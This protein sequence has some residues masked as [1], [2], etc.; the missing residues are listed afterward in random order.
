MKPSDSPSTPPHTPSSPRLRLQKTPNLQ[1]TKRALSP[2]AAKPVVALKEEKQQAQPKPAEAKKSKAVLVVSL[3]GVGVAAGGAACWYGFAPPS[4]NAAVAAVAAAEAESAPAAEVPAEDTTA[5]AVEPAAEDAAPTTEEEAAAPE[6]PA[7]PPVPQMAAEFLG[8]ALEPEESYDL[9]PASAV[10]ADNTQ[11]EEEKEERSKK[12]SPGKGELF[13]AELIDIPVVRRK[14]FTEEPQYTRL[15]TANG[16]YVVTYHEKGFAVLDFWDSHSMRY[17]MSARVADASDLD[18]SSRDLWYLYQPQ[19]QLLSFCIYQ[20]YNACT[21]DGVYLYGYDLKHRAQAPAAM[22]RSYDAMNYEVIHHVPYCRDWYM[23]S[24]YS[25]LHGSLNADEKLVFNPTPSYPGGKPLPALSQ[26]FYVADYCFSFR[27]RTVPRIEEIDAAELAWTSRSQDTAQQSTVSDSILMGEAAKL[28]KMKASDL[29]VEELAD[30]PLSFVFPKKYGTVW[31]AGRAKGFEKDPQ[32][33]FC[34]LDRQRGAVYPAIEDV[35]FW[36]WGPIPVCAMTGSSNAAVTPISIR[37]DSTGTMGTAWDGSY[38]YD[39]DHGTCY[40]TWMSEEYMVPESGFRKIEVLRSKIPGKHIATG[41]G[42]SLNAWHSGAEH[43]FWIEAGDGY[44]KLYSVDLENKHIEEVKSWNGQWSEGSETRPVWLADKQWLF[45]P[46]AENSWKI[47]HI[48]EGEGGI[49]CSLLSYLFLHSGHQYAFVLPNGHYAGTPGCESFL[50]AR[51]DDAYTDLGVLA[52][53]RNRPAEVAAALGG[54]QE[55]CEMLAAATSRWLTKLGYKPRADG[56]IGAEPNISS[57]PVAQVEAPAVKAEGSTCSFTLRLKAMATPARAE[58]RV[59]GALVE[60]TDEVPAGDC[61]EITQKVELALGTNWVEVTPYTYRDKVRVIGDTK[62]FRTICSVGEESELY[63]VTLGV[64]EYE[65]SSL[66]LQYAAKDAR[67]MAECFRTKGMGKVHALCLTDGEVRHD[68]ALQKISDFLST[69]HPGDRIVCYVAGHGLLDEKLDYYYA[70]VDIDP[71]N[72][73]AT[74]IS[75]D[76]LTDCLQQQPARQRL[77]LLD[78][79]HSGVLGE[80]GE[81]KMA[82]AMGNLPPGVRAVQHRGMKVKKVE[83]ALNTQQKKRYIETLFSMGKSQRGLNIIAGA[84]GAE[85]ALESTE[86]NNGVFTASVMEAMQQ[87]EKADKNQDGAVSVS[88]LERYTAEAVSART[89]GAQKPALSAMESPETFQLG[90]ES[91]F[92]TTSVSAAL[93]ACKSL[94]ERGIVDLEARDAKGNTPLL[95]AT[96]D[97]NS[98]LVKLLV[99]AGADVNARN[100]AGDA[101]LMN[102]ACCGDT[103]MVKLLYEHHADVNAQDKDGRNALMLAINGGHEQLAKTLA[104]DYFADTTVTDKKGEKASGLAKKKGMSELARKLGEWTGEN[105]SDAYAGWSAAQL[106]QEGG[107]LSDAGQQEQAMQL[108]RRAADAGDS[109]AQRWLGFRYLN[110]RGVAKDKNQAKFWFGKAA[111]QGDSG[112]AQA[113]KDIR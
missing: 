25:D 76:A 13:D 107:R 7:A 42:T 98:E 11:T 66:K 71:E 36:C 103:S 78:T 88:E 97:G 40:V 34:L 91:E 113:L 18:S 64:S 39:A 62:R 53:W 38:L 4:E 6:P 86:W 63:V 5:V 56:D 59:N 67:D 105:T 84:A 80:E 100:A 92:D 28:L 12:I 55:T 2:L 3:L 52:P 74:G 9:P 72:V 75:M 102:A 51:E 54:S 90:A 82:L 21:V 16:D 46:V 32:A 57:L 45:I 43:S 30:S 47:Y 96:A 26:N 24:P 77:L 85:F 17:L 23:S 112:A 93:S 58:I 27:E 65:D 109:T 31:E 20:N 29:T 99:E 33:D 89:N 61:A 104:F 10:L 49:R 111:A 94:R 101:P 1:Q 37:W 35:D 22:I 106:R 79:C 70:P 108:I 50:Y 44:C 83:T 8:A 95:K 87:P 19:S 48:E 14:E 81:E 60:E 69:A 110:G 41:C 73:A 68:T 15:L